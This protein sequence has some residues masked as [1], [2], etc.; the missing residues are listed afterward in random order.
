MNANPQ[1]E[2]LQQANQAM[3]GTLATL[4]KMLKTP[5]GAPEALL[6]K[7]ANLV[8]YDESAPERK[9]LEHQLWALLRDFKNIGTTIGI[10]GGTRVP[11]SITFK[12]D[13]VDGAGEN[14]ECAA[15]ESAHA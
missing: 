15:E 7:V 13:Q 4:A 1:I 3:S 12:L 2:L 10:S 8:G 9:R 6:N 5:K 11:Y 14:V